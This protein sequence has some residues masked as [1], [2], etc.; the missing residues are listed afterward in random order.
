MLEA[1]LVMDK[2]CATM[3]MYE[4]YNAGFLQTVKSTSN[5]KFI[6]NCVDK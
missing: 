2:E 3:R 4:N 6:N 1:Y 5:S